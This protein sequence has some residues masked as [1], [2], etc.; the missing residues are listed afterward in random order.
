MARGRP[1]RLRPA[2]AAP[3]GAAR[4]GYIA[5]R[6]PSHMNDPYAR[7]RRLLSILPLL[8]GAACAA[9][10]AAMYALGAR[11]DWPDHTSIAVGFAAGVS[12]AV[13][14]RLLRGRLAPLPPAAGLH[15]RS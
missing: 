2:E 7:R 10:A 9:A 8:L 3:I 6:P 11:P 1:G 4:M 5:P 14:T 12:I 15:C 13:V